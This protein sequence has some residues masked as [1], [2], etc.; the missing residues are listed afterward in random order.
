MIVAL[1][2][3]LRD[4]GEWK[5]R[6]T[7]GCHSTGREISCPPKVH[8]AEGANA[9]QWGECSEAGAQASAQRVGMARPLD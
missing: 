7:V 4:H 6:L 5:E 9:P 2:R 8:R 1:E 3:V